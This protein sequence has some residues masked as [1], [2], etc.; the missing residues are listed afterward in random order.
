MAKRGIVSVQIIL[1]YGRELGYSSEQLLLGSGLNTSELAQA[2]TQIEDRQELKVLENLL[3]LAG[4]G[5]RLGVELGLRYQLT[6]YG[7][8]GYALLASSTLRKAAEVGF[9]YLSLTYAF[10]HIQLQEQDGQAI[11]D[12]RCDI[13]GELG[14]MIL[15]RD[16]WAVSVIQK[17]LFAGMEIPIELHLMDSAPDCKDGKNLETLEGELGGQILFGQN[18]NAFVGLAPYLDAPLVKANDVTAQIC[19]EQCSQLLQRKQALDGVAHKVRE[20]LLHEGLHISMEEV[21]QHLART[22][23][24]LHRQLKD[25]GTSWRQLR[26]DVR[27]GLAEELLAQ[28]IQ[29]DE[30]AERLGYSDGANFSHSF[31]RCKGFTPSAYRQRLLNEQQDKT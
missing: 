23:R 10:S 22:S 12:F 9:R 25:E 26:D 5:F 27:M 31:K 14:H 20:C 2:E 18:H 28:P 3:G 8:V 15:I 11:L 24:T 21:C 19:E 30:I 4:N 7:I 16:I 17:E 6:S 29:L 13:P 1:A